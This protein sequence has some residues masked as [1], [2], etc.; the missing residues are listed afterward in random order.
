MALQPASLDSSW[1]ADGTNAPA[2]EYDFKTTAGDFKAFVDFLPTF[3][4]YPGMKLCVAVSVDR[5]PPIIVEVPGSS[6]A[7]NE[8]GTVR[9]LAVQDNYARARI[10]LSSLAAGKHTFKI[11]AIDPGVVIDRVSLP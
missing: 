11:R 8:N 6:G 10:P 7:E 9:S 1:Q 4:L 3:R 5:Q 2:L